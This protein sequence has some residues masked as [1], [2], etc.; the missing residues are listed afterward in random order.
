MSELPPLTAADVA[1]L[2]AYTD[3][4]SRFRKPHTLSALPRINGSIEA[5]LD[6]EL[7]RELAVQANYPFE[8]LDVELTFENVERFVRRAVSRLDKTTILDEFGTVSLHVT[9]KLL[10]NIKRRPPVPH[11]ISYQYGNSNDKAMHEALFQWENTYTV[12]YLRKRLYAAIM[13]AIVHSYL[14]RREYEH[15][16]AFYDDDLPPV[17]GHPSWT[18]DKRFMRDWQSWNP[19]SMPRDLQ[20]PAKLLDSGENYEISRPPPPGYEGFL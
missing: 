12:Y 7:M 4:T 15:E 11:T 6:P 19:P 10:K 2:R 16:D 5:A 14:D 13:H 17:E 1:E 18:R 9:N 3:R 8:D 20:I